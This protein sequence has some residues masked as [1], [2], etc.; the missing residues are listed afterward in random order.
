MIL[1]SY[2]YSDVMCTFLSLL[3]SSEITRCLISVVVHVGVFILL[4]NQI[5]NHYS[6]Y[7]NHCVYNCTT[8]AMLMLL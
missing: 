5:V 4:A 6:E 8:K 2:L 1:T 3:L 7:I